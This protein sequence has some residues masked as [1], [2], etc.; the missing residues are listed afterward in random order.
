M[1]W[2]LLFEHGFAS[3]R[4]VCKRRFTIL[5]IAQGEIPFIL[6]LVT[7]PNLHWRLNIEYS[8]M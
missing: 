2:V 4:Y 3:V 7:R 8:R 1:Y 5:S 6:V